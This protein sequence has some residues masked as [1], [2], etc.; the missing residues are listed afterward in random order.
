MPFLRF[1]SIVAAGLVALVTLAPGR[2]T[3]LITAADAPKPRFTRAG[4]VRVADLSVQAGAV[5]DED[6]V[7]VVGTTH[8]D[9]ESDDPNKHDAN[10]LGPNGA[11]VDLRGKKAKPFTNGHTAGI[12]SVSVGRDRIVTTSNSRDPML[13]AWDLKAGRTAPAVEIETPPPDRSNQRY[14][15]TL[16]HKSNR[17]AIALDDHVLVLDPAKPNAR[18]KFAI[19]EAEWWPGELAISRDDTRIAC[20]AG[21]CGLV[22]WDTA[23]KK[24]TSVP[25]MPANA[26]E[27]DSWVSGHA[28]FGPT[29][30]LYALR[31]GPTEVPEKTAEKD[32]PADRRSVVGIDLPDGKVLPLGLGT[33]VYTLHA[34][35]DPAGT[36]LAVVGTA[37]ADKR[38]PDGTVTGAEL[39]VYRLGTWELVHREQMDGLGEVWVAFTPSGK[40]LV[41][42]NYDGRVRWWD[43]QG[44]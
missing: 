38:L 10:R 25:L 34:A 1:D 16:F 27:A 43:V 22:V 23:T 11:I 44:K 32:V 39:R 26:D 31:H 24:A 13:R 19:P 9:A 8:C 21:K 28:M 15:A 6:A 20:T 37:H 4:E 30:A 7:V 29:G 2:N 33:S 36:W 35:I 41:T 14:R 5:I 40:R 12:F 42:A 17:V 18:A 3:G